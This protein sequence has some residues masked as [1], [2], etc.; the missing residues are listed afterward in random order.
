MDHYFVKY[1]KADNENL[2]TAT[3]IDPRYKKLSFLKNDTKK[4][5]YQSKAAEVIKNQGLVL[6]IIEEKENR[7]LSLSDSEEEKNSFTT[8]LKEIKK[9]CNYPR[10]EIG[11]FYQK[12]SD[13]FPRLA[14]CVEIFLLSP[15][16]SVPCERVFSHASFQVKYCIK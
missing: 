16:T 11:E 13:C 15:A 6:E 5:Q 2:I 9:F 1:D 3:V 10:M 4:Q 12:Y 7:K 8:P 14:K